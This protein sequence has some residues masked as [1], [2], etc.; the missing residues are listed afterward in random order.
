MLK[1]DEE[2]NETIDECGDHDQQPPHSLQIAETI[3]E[4]FENPLK[5]QPHPDF[6]KDSY[7]VEVC[8]MKQLSCIVFFLALL[9]HS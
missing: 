2:S 4:Y 6:I 7:F 5:F 8:I 9:T 3:Q 1:D